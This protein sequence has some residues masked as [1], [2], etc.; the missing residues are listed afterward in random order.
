MNSSFCRLFVSMSL[1]RPPEVPS[2]LYACFASNRFTSYRRRRGIGAG[3]GSQI[4]STGNR[5]RGTGAVVQFQFPDRLA[6]GSRRKN[7]RYRR[8]PTLLTPTG[9]HFGEEYAWLQPCPCSLVSC[10]TLG[11]AGGTAILLSFG[12]NRTQHLECTSSLVVPPC[13]CVDV[14]PL[15]ADCMQ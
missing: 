14:F 12:D 15:S 2:I 5:V 11:G 9:P 13:G 3:L 10:S 1:A 8:H 6:S 4:P 7:S